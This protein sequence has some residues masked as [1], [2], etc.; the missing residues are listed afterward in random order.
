MSHEILSFYYLI[1]FIWDHNSSPSYRFFHLCFMDFVYCVA[2]VQYP[3]SSSTI[4]LK[5]EKADS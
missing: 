5:S 3:P 4:W 2:T 1:Y